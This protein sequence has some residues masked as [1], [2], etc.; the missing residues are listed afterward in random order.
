MGRHSHFES[1]LLAKN[2]FGFNIIEAVADVL[3]STILTPTCVHAQVPSLFGAT[4]KP[5]LGIREYARR[6]SRY[7]K[8]SEECFVVSLVLLERILESNSDLAITD[9]N[10]HRLFLASSTLAAKFQDDDFYSNPHN[11]N[12]GGVTDNEMVDF[13]AKFLEMLDWRAHVSME[14]YEHCLKRLGNGSLRLHQVLSVANLPDPSRAATTRHCVKEIGTDTKP[15]KQPLCGYLQCAGS[16][17]QAVQLVDVEVEQ[18][19]YP[20]PPA[21]STIPQHCVHMDADAVQ[22]VAGLAVDNHGTQCS[23]ATSLHL[24]Q[25]RSIHEPEG[26]LCCPGGIVA[27]H[28]KQIPDETKTAQ[29]LAAEIFAPA[30]PVTHLNAC[31]VCPCLAVH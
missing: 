13:E 8:C 19:Q 2:G 16:D 31:Q 25:G 23:A 9:M 4:Q 1:T 7:L 29:Q 18:A 22:K 20:L 6:L 21:L 11:A 3:V 27:Q 5:P 12:I 17:G 10:L 28:A 14:D 26:G 15:V 24:A 30:T